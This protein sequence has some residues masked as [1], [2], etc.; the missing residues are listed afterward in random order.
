MGDVIK[1]LGGLL[2]VGLLLIGV[3]HFLG[4]ANETAEVAQEE[5]GARALVRKYE[6]FKDAAAQLDAKRAAIEVQEV[7][8][9]GME[10]DYQ[11]RPR[12]DWPRDER[13]AYQQM[14]AELAGMKNSYNTLAAEYNS[15]MSKINYAFANQG[16]LPQGASEPLPREFRTYV[17]R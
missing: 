16:Q 15:A 3:S 13:Q 12:A 11:G 6:W 8:I 2:V 9:S 5:F 14:Q 1:W 17:T 7:R 10:E 4:A